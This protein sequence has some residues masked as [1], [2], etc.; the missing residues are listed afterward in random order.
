MGE[1]FFRSFLKWQIP[2]LDSNNFRKKDGFAIKPFIGTLHLIN[3]VNK[4]WKA[5][6]EEP[7]EYAIEITKSTNA[8]FILCFVMTL[9]FQ[10]TYDI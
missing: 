6:K 8:N 10:N 3:E 1:I 2:N 7:V 5:V 9:Y 4:K